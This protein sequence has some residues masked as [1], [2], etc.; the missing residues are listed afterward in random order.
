MGMSWLPLCSPFDWN[1]QNKCRTLVTGCV[2]MQAVTAREL[3]LKSL[4]FVLQDLDVLKNLVL[5][6]LSQKTKIPAATGKDKI[7]AYIEVSLVGFSVCC[8]GSGHGLGSSRGLAAILDFG[9]THP[10]PRSTAPAAG[11]LLVLGVI[12]CFLCCRASATS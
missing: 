5:Y 2:V 4:V 8:G 11:G 1:V 6:R 7:R 10:G 3:Q 9:E 12:E